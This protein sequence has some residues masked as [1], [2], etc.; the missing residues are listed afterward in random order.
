MQSHGKSWI[1]RYK[2]GCVKIKISLYSVIL[3]EVKD[4]ENASDAYGIDFAERC[5][6]ATQ[7]D[8]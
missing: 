5:F 8:K 6:F 4:L 2:T 3:N 7:N 1:L